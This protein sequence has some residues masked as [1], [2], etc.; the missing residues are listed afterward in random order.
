MKGGWVYILE[1]S[2]GSYYTGSTSLLERRMGQ[3]MEGVYDGY[4]AARRPVKLRWTQWS[5]DIR[6]AIAFER[7]I[8]GWTR[9][10]KEALINDDH[11]LLHFLSECKNKSH[12]KNTLL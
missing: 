2:D 12:C 3:H 7:Q 9:R 4:T 1:C 10:K 8:K 11:M 6:D 5:P